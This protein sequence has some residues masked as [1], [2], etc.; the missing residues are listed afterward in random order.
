MNKFEA[1][2]RFAQRMKDNYPPGTRIMLLQMGDDPRPVEPNTRGTVAVVDDMGTLH[3]NFDNG[4]QLGI[5]PG[6]DS[7]RKLTSEELAEEQTM[8]E[9]EDFSMK[10][11]YGK[12]YCHHS[13]TMEEAP[14][15]EAIMNAILNTAKSNPDILQT[16]KM[17]IQMGLGAE[18]G[19]DESMDIQIRIAQIDREFNDIL[20]TVTAENPESLLTDPRV[21]TLMSEK[22]MLE[23]KLA[24][25]EAAEQHRKNAKSRL[26]QIFTV[27]D[28]MKNHPLTF[29][30]EIIRKILQ[31]VIVESKDRIKVVFLGGLEVETEVEQ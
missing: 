10:M 20:N 31:C 13:P 7:F 5:V 30:N 23:K 19:E 12:K 27:L 15:Q 1:E 28:G 8:A 6:E 22:R 3:C 25:Y 17:H 14:L 24:E 18:A 16:L 29:D 21:E 9:S 26:E 4:R 11:Q 2:R